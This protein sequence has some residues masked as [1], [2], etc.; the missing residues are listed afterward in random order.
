MERE[1]NTQ[2]GGVRWEY[3]I[4]EE[5]LFHPDIG[6]Y[7]AYG[8][9]ASELRP[10]AVLSDVAL[11]EEEAARIARAFERAQ[12]CPARLRD[13]VEAVLAGQCCLQED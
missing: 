12:L 8:I 9:R 6:T 1:K 3:H 4:F 7:T 11:R 2:E 5:R 10:V 13:A